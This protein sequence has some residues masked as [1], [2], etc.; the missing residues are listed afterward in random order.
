MFVFIWMCWQL[1]CGRFSKA[2]QKRQLRIAG[3]ARKTCQKRQLRIAGQASSQAG[4]R[5]RHSHRLRR[6]TLHSEACVRQSGV[7]YIFQVFV[8]CHVAL[9]GN[10]W[11]A[12]GA[13]LARGQDLLLLQS[14]A[15]CPRQVISC[16]SST[17]RDG[18]GWIPSFL[19]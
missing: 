4:P 10:A 3:Q 11:R 8:C 7:M 19:A 12:A 15:R 9:S 18:A 14:Q 6:E 16:G 17:H 5:M 13:R 2:C 1:F